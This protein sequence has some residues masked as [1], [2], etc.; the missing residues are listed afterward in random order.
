MRIVIILDVDVDPTLND[1][2]EVAE[3]FLL[4][5]IDGTRYHTLD[6]LPSY[7]MGH[8]VKFVSAEWAR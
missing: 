6:D 1:P 8:S 2:H 4:D 3:E 5:R 7:G